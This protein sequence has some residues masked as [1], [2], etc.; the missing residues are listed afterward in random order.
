MKVIVFCKEDDGTEVARNG[1]GDRKLLERQELL[2]NV[3]YKHAVKQ[4]VGQAS[5]MQ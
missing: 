2:D 3:V 5:H 1:A 4:S